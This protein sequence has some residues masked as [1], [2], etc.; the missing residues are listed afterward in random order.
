MHHPCRYHQ[1]GVPMMHH[2][3]R[4]HQ[5]GDAMMHQPRDAMVLLFAIDGPINAPVV[6]AADSGELPH[7]DSAAD[8]F[9]DEAFSL[10]DCH[11]FEG[12]TIS[13]AQ[14]IQNVTCF[15]I[16]HASLLNLGMWFDVPTADVQHHFAQFV[17]RQSGEWQFAGTDGIG[18]RRYRIFVPTAPTVLLWSGDHL[19]LD[20]ILMNI[21]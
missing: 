13:A 4:Y 7:I 8:G 10:T 15:A 3:R 21:A 5:N 17:P 9:T 11:R 20:R 19:G 6:D 16:S 1:N 12:G 2:P 18:G 14:L